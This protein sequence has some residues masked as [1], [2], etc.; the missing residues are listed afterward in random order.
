MSRPRA[1]ERGDAAPRPPSTAERA[2]L[3]VGVPTTAGATTPREDVIG[4][5]QLAAEVEH[6]LLVQY[7]YAA[8]SVDMTVGTDNR[9]AHRQ[10]TTIAIQE[11]GHLVAVQNLLLAM[12]GPDAYHFGRDGIRASSDR[13]PLPLVLERVSHAALAKFITVERPDDLADPALKKRV[14]DLGAEASSDAQFTLHPVMAL[15]NAIYWI[16]QPD[17]SPFGRMTPPADLLRE[18]WHLKPEDF[19]AAAVIDQ[20]ASSSS[21]WG[22]FPG[23]TVFPVHHAEEACDLLADVM[24]QGEG[25]GEKHTESHFTGFLHVLDAFEANRIAVIHLCR[26]PTVG[27]QP[28]SEDPQATLIENPYAHLWARL[29]NIRYT[30]LVLTIGHTVSLPIE[31]SNRMALSSIALTMM[32]PGLSDVI[33]HLTTLDV[34]AAGTAKAGPPFGLLDDTLPQEPAA[35][36]ARHRT[37]LDQNASAVTAITNSAEFSRDAEAPVVLQLFAPIDEA[38]ATLLGSVS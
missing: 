8:A 16:F 21:E 17:D 10:I 37:F 32:R 4:L 15:Y 35:F 27:D 34:D 26:T 28:A 18:G 22:G 29:F 1:L 24:E 19:V 31:D 23:L 36:W 30:E 14:D 33:K 20:F 3:A 11:M 25:G 2:L 6:A 13:N 9:K 5:L 12:A 7:L 38:L